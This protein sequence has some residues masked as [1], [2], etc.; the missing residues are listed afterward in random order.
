GDDESSVVVRFPVAVPP[1][2]NSCTR[3]L[4]CTASPAVTVGAG[5]K[6][7]I[8]SEGASLASGLA[9]C[10]PKPFVDLAVT[11]PPVHTTW[12]LNGEMCV[13]PWMSWIA[14]N[15][16]ST[17]KG[18]EADVDRDCAS[19][20]VHESVFE[21]GVVPAAIVAANENVLSPAAASP[22]V[23]SSKNVCEE[24]PPIAVRAQGTPRLVLGG[25]VPGVTATVS[26]VEPPAGADA[27]PAA[28]TPV[29]GVELQSWSAEAVLRGLGAPAVKSAPLLLVSVQP[30]LLRS[31]AVVFDA[32]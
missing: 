2:R 7:K 25:L 32:A 30:E 12:P 29:G 6:T 27:G 14:S 5:V 21:P 16:P 15:G 20:T 13:A 31:T 23:P 24:P 18:I 10:I 17:E 4:T 1:G 26:S 28:P 9:L 3:A 11:T 22:F 19:K 8:P